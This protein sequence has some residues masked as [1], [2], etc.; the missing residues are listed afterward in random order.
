MRFII[1]IEKVCRKNDRPLILYCNLRIPHGQA[2]H[3]SFDLE[4]YHHQYVEIITII[5]YIYVD[6]A[7]IYS[8]IDTNKYFC[9]KIAHH[10]SQLQESVRVACPRQDRNVKKTMYL[11]I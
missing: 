4:L 7:N 1:K 3:D 6:A 8:I 2:T 5:V 9:E 10:Q 11:H